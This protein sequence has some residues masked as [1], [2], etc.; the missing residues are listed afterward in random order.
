MEQRSSA[1]ADVRDGLQIVGAMGLFAFSGGCP[2][3]RQVGQGFRGPCS[4]RCPRIRTGGTP[5]AP[6]LTFHLGV[7]RGDVNAGRGVRVGPRA[8]RTG[9]T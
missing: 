4:I 5:L 9:A 8:I 3:S 2:V 7:V 6:P 1:Q